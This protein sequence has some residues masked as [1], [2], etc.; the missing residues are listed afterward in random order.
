[1]SIEISKIQKENED[2]FCV[3]YKKQDFFFEDNEKLI[4]NILSFCFETNTFLFFQDFFEDLDLK[5][6]VINTA[7]D[8]LF[9]KDCIDKTSI[10]HEKHLIFYR[11]DVFSMS[12]ISAS[13]NL[14]FIITDSISKYKN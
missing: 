13:F 11:Y 4:D 10:F 7:K 8:N 6:D 1:M 2:Y 12:Y 14:F 9:M 3:N 5:L